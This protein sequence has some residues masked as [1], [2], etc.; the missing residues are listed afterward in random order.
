MRGRRTLSPSP[1]LQKLPPLFRLFLKRIQAGAAGRF[2]QRMTGRRRGG[3]SPPADV[4]ERQHWDAYQHAVA[5]AHVVWCW[6]LQSG[7]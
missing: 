7:S 3:N 1:E 2:L 5:S 6:C 4:R